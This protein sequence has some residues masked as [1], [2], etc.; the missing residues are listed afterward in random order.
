MS[1]FYII[2]VHNL[3]RASFSSLLHSHA[4]SFTIQIQNIGVTLDTFAYISKIELCM[5][6]YCWNFSFLFS[7]C[8]FC[9]LLNLL[10]FFQFQCQCDCVSVY[11]VCMNECTCMTLS[12]NWKRVNGNIFNKEEKETYKYRKMFLLLRVFG[13]R[14]RVSLETKISMFLYTHR[15][16]TPFQVFSSSI[17]FLRIKNCIQVILLLLFF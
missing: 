10:I 8:T 9:R 7:R 11:A 16:F 15:I 2:F 3:L 14:L 12:I 17:P 6:S 4:C 13:F 1:F 5:F